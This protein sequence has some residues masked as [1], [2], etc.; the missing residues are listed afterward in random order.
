MSSYLEGSISP[1]NKAI[2]S[3]WFRA[4]AEALQSLLPFADTGNP[5]GFH[6]AG[7]LPLFTFGKTSKTYFPLVE[8]IGEQSYTVTHYITPGGVC[9]WTPF[10]VDD[11]TTGLGGTLTEGFPLDDIGPS[12]L[13]IVK[14]DGGGYFLQMYLLT[15][16]TGDG[17]G[18]GQN[19]HVAITSYGVGSPTGELLA[20]NVETHWDFS[21]NMF[22]SESVSPG[23]PQAVHITSSDDGGVALRGFGN[24][25]FTALQGIEIQPD[26]WHH[27]LLSFDISLKTTAGSTTSNSSNGDYGNT[28]SFVNATLSNRCKI[29]AALDDVNYTGVPLRASFDSYL[30]PNDF[31]SRN[32][33]FA[34]LSTVG[35]TSRSAGWGVS[36]SW[37]DGI[38]S[39]LQMTFT[40]HGGEL[41]T[42]SFGI[43]ASSDT[44]DQMHHVEMAEFQVWT[45]KTLDTSS[46]TQ[47]RLFIAP[48][49]N[50]DGGQ[51]LK[52]VTPKT[53][54]KELGDPDIL[55]H[56]SSNWKKGKNTGTA[57]GTGSEFHPTGKIESFKPEPE[58]GK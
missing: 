5:A 6:R 4:P 49:K 15:G 57:S 54:S 18:F 14:G 30:G 23:N 9:D 37:S 24:D 55:L 39:S 53:A 46:V 1:F 58:V 32:T 20:C 36:G 10:L 2:I 43:P 56:R 19:T 35:G 31:V 8:T 22:L 47:R 26:T 12:Y 45:G 3:L 51:S 48:K 40:A 11:Q 38:F 42:D 21:Q 50:S 29:W 33:N 41:P 52:P 7:V 28:S 34:F 27:L 25:D 17:F 13:G 16:A 44:A